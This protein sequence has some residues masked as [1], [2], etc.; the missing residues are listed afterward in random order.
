MN[1]S[2]LHKK[3]LYKASH[4]GSKEL[5]ILLANF[6]SYCLS[7]LK[8]DGS[9]VKILEKFLEEEDPALLDYFFGRQ[10]LPSY[11]SKCFKDMFLQ[12]HTH[13]ILE[14]KE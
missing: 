1:A 12:Y 8:I 11:V 10:E 2:P 13:F 5:D 4:R 7:Y 6:V 3:L 14:K 9:T